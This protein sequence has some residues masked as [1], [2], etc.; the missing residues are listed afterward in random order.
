MSS[1]WLLEFCSYMFVASLGIAGGFWLRGKVPQLLHRTVRSSATTDRKQIAE[2][3][4][5]SLHS[6]AETVRS[7]VQQH[8][9]CIQT[10]NRELQGASATEPAI[11]NNAAA[12]IIAANGLVKHQFDDIQ[13]TLE[14]KKEEISDCLDSSGSLLLTFASLDRQK[15]IY[16]QVLTSLEHL[17]AELTTEV[18]GHG[19]QLDK[20]SAGLQAEEQ[21]DV[22]RIHGAVA[23][24]VDAAG[25]LQRKV[26]TAEKRIEHQAETIEMQAVLSHTDLLTSLPN[27]RAF[28]SELER[29]TGRGRGRSMCTVIFVDLDLFSQVNSEYGHHGGDVIL[30]QTAAIIKPLVRGKDLV[31][32]YAG[33][34][35]A[36][37]LRDTTVHDALPLAERA[38]KLI[39]S[40]HFSHGHHPLRIT[41]SVGIA[42]LRP[43]ELPSMVT[44]HAAMALRSAQQAGGNLCFRHD[45]QECHPV[46]AAFQAKPESSRDSS[47]TLASMWRESAENDET[48]GTGRL[49]A[50]K[51]DNAPVLSGRSLFSANL[52]RRLSEWK[53]GGP[54]VS[55]LV[56]CVDQMQE[57]VDRFGAKGHSFLQQVLGRLLEATTRDMDERCEFEDGLFALL[58]P[59]TDEANALAVADRLRSQV[60]QCKVR[61]GNDLWDLTAS[62]GLAHCTVASRVMDIMLSAEAAMNE[63]ARLGG[64]AVRVGEPVSEEQLNLKS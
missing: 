20:I 39:E 64:D 9:D 16:R 49:A 37:V 53:R 45:G 51:E 29:V 58:L 6:A 2:Q 40:G 34:T 43:E 60:R 38:R 30:R 14:E 8:I 25:D 24:I 21:R 7:C 61:M 17:A 31:A 59:G 11:L 19:R 47:L 62:I 50:V 28:D 48:L 22:A 41:A 13:R 27:R 36:I 57:L 35:F 46:S 4:L 10:I 18:T 56:M 1:M 23:Q 15:H 52:N 32:R 63:A 3:A 12:S 54:T 55:V 42:Q 33:D 5:S 44:E 26:E